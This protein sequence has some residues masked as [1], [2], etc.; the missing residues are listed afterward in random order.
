[1]TL[2]E[3]KR[4]LLKDPSATNTPLLPPTER[5]LNNMYNVEK[6]QTGRE[7]QQKPDVEFKIKPAFAFLHPLL[8]QNHVQ[9]NFHSPK[10]SKSNSFID[11]KY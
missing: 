4:V 8:K 1:M 7:Q 3:E 6:T 2:Q 11:T 10:S 9:K 5:Q